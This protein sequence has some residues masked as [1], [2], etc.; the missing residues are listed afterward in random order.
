MRK[1]THTLYFVFAIVP[2]H[3]FISQGLGNQKLENIHMPSCVQNLKH[4][5]FDEL[6][7]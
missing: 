6:F 3:L 5:K 4:N 1:Y 7:I 2:L